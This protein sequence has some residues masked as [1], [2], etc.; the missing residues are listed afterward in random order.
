MKIMNMKNMKMNIINMN[1]MNYHEHEK[2]HKHRDID[3]INYSENAG[4]SY[5]RL[6]FLHCCDHFSKKFR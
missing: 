6:P 2:G 1:I 3:I 4:P 5:I